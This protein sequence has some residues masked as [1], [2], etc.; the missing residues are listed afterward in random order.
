MRNMEVNVQHNANGVVFTTPESLYAV[1]VTRNVDNQGQ[2][3]HYDVTILEADSDVV[4]ARMVIPTAGQLK[5]I[6]TVNRL[7]QSAYEHMFFEYENF[8][9]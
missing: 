2:L 9:S 6:W 5:R 1:T 8:A 7:F 4:V 3:V